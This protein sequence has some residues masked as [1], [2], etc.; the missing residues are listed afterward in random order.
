MGP[1]RFT[2]AVDGLVLIGCQV[3]AVAFVDLTS[4]ILVTFVIVEKVPE[5]V[6]IG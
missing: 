3:V 4:K 2:T 1:L 5:R 6:K